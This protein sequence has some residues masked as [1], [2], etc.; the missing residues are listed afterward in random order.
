MAEPFVA[1]GPSGVAIRTRLK[2]LTA[3]DEEVLRLVGAHLGGLASKDL[4]ARCRDGLEHSVDAWAARKREL[5]P[6][7]SSRWAGSITKASH[8]QWA[9][10]RRGQ[11]AHIQSLEAGIRAITH[12][13]SLP[14]GQRGTKQAPGGYRSRREWHAK[15]RRLHV[16]QDRL[17]AERADRE[18]G[19]VHVVRGGKRL[20]RTRHHLEAARLSEREWRRRWEA[21]RWFL[22]ADGESGKRHGNETIRVSPEGE[23]SIKLPAPLAHLA[24]AGHGRYVL[25]SRV[26]FAHRGAEWADR[27]AANRAVAYRIHYDTGRDR[28]YLT[29][30]WQIPP[31]PTIPLAAA[32]AHGV[33]GIDM[34][35]DHLAAWRLDAHGNP[36]GHP[37]RFF[38]DLTG[39]A[40][41][42][43]AQVRHAL[44]RLLH[45]AQACGVKAIA[46]EDLDF[47][48]EKTREKHGRRKRFRQLI[49]GMPTAR[50][51]ARLTSM[52]DQTG[53]AVIAVDPAYTSRWGAQHWQKP[54]TSTTR[55][56]TRHD[57]AAVAIGRRA[58]GHP[59]RRRTAPPPHDQSDRAGHRTVQARPG[60]PGR[61]GT[62][63]RI[64]GPRTRSVRAGR[65]ANAGHQNTQHRSGCSAEHEPWQQD[66]LP[67]SP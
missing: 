22:A 54:L 66:T 12:R 37:R 64:P 29:A 26:R 33:I 45:W 55:R 8:D 7:S 35:A 17:E 49:S 2:Q 47:T 28:W 63:P 11:L 36:I 53:I 42:R 18:A 58:Q 31:T 16:L 13:L 61:E 60:I 43:D 62:R 48:A 14:V 15:A 5:T 19:V 20:A 32:L 65:G 57:A 25:A 67:L 27:V 59:I 52:A 4:R 6:L 10:A 51:R 38:Y 50:L 3:G 34:N 24:N 41:H 44:T 21:E 46:V 56:T 1:S 40:Q 39:T 9:L 30:A 23:V